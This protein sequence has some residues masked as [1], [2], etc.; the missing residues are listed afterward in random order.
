MVNSLSLVSADAAAAAADAQLLSVGPEG[1]EP[2]Y[3]R[4]P[5]QTPKLGLRGEGLLFNL[6]EGALLG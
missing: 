3:E 1:G 2:L 6:R 4:H 5:G